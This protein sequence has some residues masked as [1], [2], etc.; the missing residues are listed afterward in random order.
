MVQEEYRGKYKIDFTFTKSPH[1]KER[2]LKL[3]REEGQLV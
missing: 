1:S 3:G 2:T